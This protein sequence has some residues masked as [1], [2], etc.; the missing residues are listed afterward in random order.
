MREPISNDLLGYGAT[1]R[2]QA[3]HMHAKPV[4]YYPATPFA[5]S[6]CVNLFCLSEQDLTVYPGWSGIRHVDQTGLELREVPRLKAKGT[7]VRAPKPS[8]VSALNEA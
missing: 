2:T 4:L 7:H 5:L 8:L 3:L 1:G 6:V